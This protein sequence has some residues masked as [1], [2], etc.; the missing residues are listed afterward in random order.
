VNSLLTL[1][2]KVDLSL[3][4]ISLFDITRIIEASIDESN[5]LLE[6]G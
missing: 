2:I 3:L 6:V 5:G 4:D 1:D